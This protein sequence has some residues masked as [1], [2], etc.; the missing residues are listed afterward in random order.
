[1][2]NM[3]M[4]KDSMSGK[5][6]VT[7]AVTCDFVCDDESAVVITRNGGRYALQ[8]QMLAALL[9]EYKGAG[10]KLVA[11][12]AGQEPAQAEAPKEEETQGE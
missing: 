11:V 7:D 4:F 3:I 5:T 2:P 6:I 10:I 9:D 1:M 12:Q 8:L